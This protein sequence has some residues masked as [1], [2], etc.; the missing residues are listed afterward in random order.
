[1]VTDSIEPDSALLAKYKTVCENALR[2]LTAGLETGDAIGRD[3]AYSRIRESNE[4]FIRNNGGK[5]GESSASA[6]RGVVE[7]IIAQDVRN[8]QAPAAVTDEDHMPGSGNRAKPA[9]DFRNAPQSAR[10]R[11]ALS[12]GLVGFGI[13]AFA[14]FAFWVVGAPPADEVRRQ[15]L[16][17]AK[18]A[19]SLP[20]VEAAAA[21]LDRVSQEIVK[22]Q[23]T[24]G[25]AL[26]AIAGR[27]PVM[28]D[29]VLPEI[30]KE[31]P[32]EMPAGT[33]LLVR[34]TD[35]AYKIVFR[36]R[37]C[38]AVEFARPEMIDRVREP[39]KAGGLGCE[40][41]GVWN[42]PGARF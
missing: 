10:P 6:F 20:Q 9:A 39:A 16:F 34:A 7:E 15:E 42:K 8:G 11:S 21:F 3:V 31:M 5:F 35:T 40:F 37:L 23:E 36:S 24:D 33:V 4:A 27:R 18:F 22:R 17:E 29:K 41:F 26:A 32:A 14:G 13:A 28:L 30:A 12:G 38:T 1:M 2:R 25:A 19:K